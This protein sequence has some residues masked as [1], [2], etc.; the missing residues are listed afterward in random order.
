[1]AEVFTKDSIWLRKYFQV[2]STDQ[3]RLPEKQTGLS[4]RQNLAGIQQQNGS[5]NQQPRQAGFQ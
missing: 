1:M 3:E 2:A 4:H 5:G